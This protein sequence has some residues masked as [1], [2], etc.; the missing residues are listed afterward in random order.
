[1]NKKKEKLK[2][3]EMYQFYRAYYLQEYSDLVTLAQKNLSAK[4][5]RK[6]TIKLRDF[7]SGVSERYGSFTRKRLSPTNLI[8]DHY[9]EMLFREYIDFIG[10]RE[11]ERHGI[12]AFIIQYLDSIKERFA[13]SERSEQHTYPEHYAFD[14]ENT[15]R[16]IA[17]WE[18]TRDFLE[19]LMSVPDTDA[20]K[21]ILDKLNPDYRNLSETKPMEADNGI[22]LTKEE[23]SLSM[24]QQ[25]IILCY[26]LDKIGGRNINYSDRARFI[27]KLTRMSLDNIYDVVRNPLDYNSYNSFKKDMTI[28]WNEL[29]MLGL[30]ELAETVLKDM[31]EN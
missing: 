4:D 6:F 8:P 22:D 5:G 11:D 27:K 23:K 31:R 2:E 7:I 9:T 17:K 21:T 20:L 14:Q 16:L 12:G 28:V 1:M 26:L 13:G 25:T 30:N 19:R 3:K 18:A 29:N 10:E 24:R 15:I